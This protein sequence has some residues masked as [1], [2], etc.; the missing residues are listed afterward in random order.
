M[1]II[2][3]IG[4]FIAM[5]A[6]FPVFVVLMFPLMGIL[7]LIALNPF[8]WL[9]VGIIGLLF[10]V[11]IKILKDVQNITIA[12]SSLGIVMMWISLFISNHEL[13]YNY[14]NFSNPAPAALGGFP[15]TVF[16]YPPAALGSNVPPV[17]SWGLF[18]LNFI[19][20]IIIGAAMSI[21]LRK[22]FSRQVSFKLFAASIIISL[23]GLGYLMLKFD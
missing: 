17:D 3:S 8:S 14:I 4:T 10:A 15:I 18:Y 2:E 7:S 23:Y 20:W 13:P 12:V 6:V 22:H 19:F 1:E 5:V 21:A 11:Q 16:E 9:Y